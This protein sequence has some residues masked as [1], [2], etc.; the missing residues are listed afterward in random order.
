M[1]EFQKQLIKRLD[2]LIRLQLDRGLPESPASTT[3]I[4]H[5]LLDLGFSSAETA[6]IIGKPLNYVTA[7]SSAKRA[8][9]RKPQKQEKAR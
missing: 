1:D 6:S 4:V 8:K 3:S 5:R 2:L 7:L 9:A